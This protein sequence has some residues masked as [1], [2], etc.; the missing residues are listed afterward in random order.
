VV[1]TP[2]DRPFRKFLFGFRSSCIDDVSH[3]SIPDHSAAFLTPRGPIHY[4]GHKTPS[5]LFTQGV[6]WSTP[7]GSIGLSMRKG[8][9]FKSEERPY[10]EKD[11]TARMVA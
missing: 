11:G 1:A 6:A 4:V 2:F 3:I 5:I 10:K 8:D 7:L 9:A